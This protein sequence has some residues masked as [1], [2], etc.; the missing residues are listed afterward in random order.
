MGRLYRDNVQKPVFVK[1]ILD[2][3]LYLHLPIGKY[4]LQMYKQRQLAIAIFNLA[5]AG[6]S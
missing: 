4:A 5:T 1:D 2:S 6:N 3:V